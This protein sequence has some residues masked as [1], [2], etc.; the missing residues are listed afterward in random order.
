M[1][2][3]VSVA[4]LGFGVLGLSPVAAQAGA[5]PCR[6]GSVIAS[7][8]TAV[9]QPGYRPTANLTCERGFLLPPRFGCVDEQL[10]IDGAAAEAVWSASGGD[11]G[12]GPAPGKVATASTSEAPVEAPVVAAADGGGAVMWSD[13]WV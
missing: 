10:A 4:A 11:A 1:P 13:C 9:C 2:V 12:G 3:S 8:C 6:E 5:S 7:R